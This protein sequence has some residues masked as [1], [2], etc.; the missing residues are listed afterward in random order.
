MVN[1]YLAVFIP[2]FFNKEVLVYLFPF[3]V[4]R[5]YVEKQDLFLD[6][7]AV[8]VGRQEL[9]EETVDGV[10]CYKVEC[11]AKDTTEKN[12]RRIV[13]IGK[14]NFMLYKAEFYDRQDLLQRVLTCSEI[15]MIDGFWTTGK[16]LMKNVQKDHST[17]IEMKDVKYGITLDETLFTVSAL[18]KG[19]VR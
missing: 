9:D 18:E 2:Y 15:K 14:S 12:P 11:R 13:W 3:R 10:A 16:M 5:I 8:S 4:V 6:G 17:V 1:V 19:R 7:N